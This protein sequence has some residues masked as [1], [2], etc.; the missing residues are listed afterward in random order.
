MYGSQKFNCRFLYILYRF[1]KIL[2][3]DRS[4]SIILYFKRWGNFTDLR[5]TV[6]DLPVSSVSEYHFKRYYRR[7]TESSDEILR[8]YQ[9]DWTSAK[10]RCFIALFG[11]TQPVC[12]I[13]RKIWLRTSYKIKT[14][15]LS[16]TIPLIKIGRQLVSKSGYES[17]R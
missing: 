11:V 17:G 7:V 15:S 12:S 9:A 13:A 6:H 3:H 14:L 5:S 16:Q 2:S 4:E 1:S 8:Q 10:L